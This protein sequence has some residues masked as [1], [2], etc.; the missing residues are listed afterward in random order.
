MTEFSK[1]VVTYIQ[2][3]PKGK[4]AS[5]SQLAKLAGNPRG[6]RGVV[7]ILHSQTASKNLPWHRVMNAKGRI[8]FPEMSPNWVTQRKLLEREGVVFEYGDRI[9]MITYQW[10]PKKLTL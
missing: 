4:V 2:K 1:K 9:D 3:I 8:S 10:K 5:Y 7:W 6:T